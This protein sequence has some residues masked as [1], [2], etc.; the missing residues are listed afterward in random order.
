[1]VQIQL[2][3]FYF[4]NYHLHIYMLY[5]VCPED[6]QTFTMKNRDIY[7]RKYKRKETLYIG[8]WCLSLL[9]IGHLGA[10]TV[11]PIPST[12]L[13]FLESHRWSEISSFSKVT[14]VLEKASS[15]RAPNLGYRGWATW[16]IWC[17]AK[18]RCRCD[19]WGGTLLCWSC[20]SPVAHS[21]GLLNHP[22]SFHGGMFKLNA[23]FD[24]DLLLYSLCRFEYNNYTVPMLIQLASTIPTD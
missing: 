13:Y 7:W 21:W 11:L 12:V 19:A 20:Q 22:N 24:A 8:Q 5:R 6:I 2:P 4:F 14:L 15:C 23:N 17:L 1:M 18:K 16:V 10:S 3:Q 9:Q